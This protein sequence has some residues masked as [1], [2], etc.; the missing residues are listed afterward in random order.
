[1]AR[2]G[3][4]NSDVG[5]ACNLIGELC[6]RCYNLSLDNSG[7]GVVSRT[8]R[9]RVV[10]DNPVNP[11]PNTEFEIILKTTGLSKEEKLRRINDIL[12]KAI[13]NNTQ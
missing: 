4:C 5:C 7:E 13:L 1:M 10:Y 6:A 8:R 12:E 11:A 3:K 2:C 9:K